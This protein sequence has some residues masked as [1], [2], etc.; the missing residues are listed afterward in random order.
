MRMNASLKKNRLSTGRRTCKQRREVAPPVLSAYHIRTY[1]T[2]A[3]STFTKNICIDLVSLIGYSQTIQP[4]EYQPI[5]LAE[6]QPLRRFPPQHVQ[7]MTQHH[8]LCFQRDPRL[9]KPDQRTPDQSADLDHQADDS[10]DS[11]PPAKL[12][13]RQGQLS[14]T[15]QKSIKVICNPIG[16]RKPSRRT[17]LH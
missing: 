12:G 11:P 16:S 9:E 5:E 14:A 13:F 17:T 8:D 1:C 7:L 15:S 3:L 4:G 6:G 2:L 10:P